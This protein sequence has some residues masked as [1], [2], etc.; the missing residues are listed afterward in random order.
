MHVRLQHEQSL[1]K[2]LKGF[3]V[4]VLSRLHES[5]ES[6]VIFQPQESSAVSRAFLEISK[7]AEFKSCMKFFRATN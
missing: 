7:T 6:G 1:R 3:I 4:E 5:F 2:F